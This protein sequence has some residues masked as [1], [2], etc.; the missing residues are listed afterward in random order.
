VKL[1]DGQDLPGEDSFD[2]LLIMGGPM[3]VDD[4]DAHPWLGPERD[5]IGRAVAGGRPVLGICL[6][7]QLIASTL[8]SAVY[9]RRP[10]EI[11]LFDIHLTDAGQADPLLGFLGST[12]EVFHWHGDTFDLPK[13]AMHLA[14]SERFVNQAFRVGESVYGLQFHFECTTQIVRDLRHICAKELAELPPEDA[15]DQFVE[16]LPEAIGQQN[17]WARRFIAGWAGLLG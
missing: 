1:Y 9:P 10:K 4:W 5:F 3:N 12:A 8:G 6:G 17:E 15:F 13:R 16:R 14:E 7:A 2:G 11:G